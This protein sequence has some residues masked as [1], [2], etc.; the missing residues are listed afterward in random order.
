ML[1]KADPSRLAP[2]ADLPLSG[3]VRRERSERKVTTC[4]GVLCLADA[5]HDAHRDGADPLNGQRA[6]RVA[7]GAAM[8]FAWALPFAGLLLTIATGPTLFRHF[9]HSHYGKIALG[10]SLLVLVPLA[11]TYGGGASVEA[12]A[13]ALLGEYL[14]FIIVLFALYTVAGG[15][16][17]TG[18]LR[19]TPATNTAILAFGTAIASV[20]GTTGAAMILI[21]PLIAA[22]L[23]R[24]HRV[25][26][27]VF[28]ILLVANVGGALTPLGDPPL[29]VGFLRGVD[30]FWPAQHLWLQTAIVAGLLLAMFFALDSYL[31]RKEERPANDAP[32]RCRSTA[33][34][35]SR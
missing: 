30:F 31:S 35:T 9:W 7:N 1:I 11:L 4:T 27:I 20:V 14:S 23:S 5:S 21:R 12:L 22:N 3:E 17:V 19:G 33:R 13:H 29:F 24:V 34:S 10:W 6:R 2:L 15:I 28:F 18:N 26:V 32:S 16:L 8:S 25:H